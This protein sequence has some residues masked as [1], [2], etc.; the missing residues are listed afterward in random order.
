MLRLAVLPEWRRQGVAAA[1][2]DSGR[3]RL[4][5]SGVERVL[6]EVRSANVPARSLYEH[7]GFTV[8]GLRRKYYRKP[9][10]DAVVLHFLM[11]GSAGEE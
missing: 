6:V 4:Q 10:D 2:L 11:N 5:A 7:Y 3:N 1:L 8:I 9:S